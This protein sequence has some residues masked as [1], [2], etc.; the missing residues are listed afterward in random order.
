[1][2]WMEW[3]GIVSGVLAVVGVVFNNYS[4][5]ACFPIWL[6]SN[7]TSAYLHINAG[8]WGLAA[9][10]ASFFGLAIMGLIMWSRKKEQRN[11]E[12]CTHTF[13]SDIENCHHTYCC[14]HNAG[15]VENCVA[16]SSMQMAAVDCPRIAHEAFKTKG[17]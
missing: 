15:C 17:A 9:R 2:G 16:I 7:A 1:M 3:V 14:Y 10:D 5:R 13:E 8:M 4:S 12:G 11:C 6:V